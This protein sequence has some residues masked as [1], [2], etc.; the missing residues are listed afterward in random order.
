MLYSY[1]WLILSKKMKYPE[2]D[3]MHFEYAQNAGNGF[4]SQKFSLLR[5]S[6]FKR[7]I[8]EPA[9]DTLHNCTLAFQ[10]CPEYWKWTLR[11]LAPPCS[12]PPPTHTYTH[13]PMPNILKSREENTQKLTQLSSRSHPR[14]LVRKRTAQKDTII[15]ITSDSQVNSIF[16]NRWSPASLTFN[17]Y[18]YLF[19]IYSFK[20]SR[21]VYIHTYIKYTNIHNIY[22]HTH[23][24]HR[25]GL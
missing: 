8:E 3:K 14:H 17:N 21:Q 25:I 5:L 24:C 18:I 12:T 20:I 11:S 16:P 7:A 10:I 2:A 15:D 4:S 1:F 9:I 19:F 13:I 6:D 22:I 23:T